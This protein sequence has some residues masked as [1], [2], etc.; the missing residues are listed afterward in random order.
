MYPHRRKVFTM[1]DFNSDK[2]YNSVNGTAPD[3]Y[4]W[5]SAPDKREFKVLGTEVT[6]PKN[7]IV[8]NANEV[9]LYAYYVLS[10]SIVSFE[11]TA[12][13]NERIYAISSRGTLVLEE[14]VILQQPVPVSFKASRETRAI[15]ISRESLL[16]AV[17]SDPDI[18]M[19]II[20]S[21][22]AKLL[23]AM[24]VI[25]QS[26]S[27]SAAWKICNLLLIFASQY[28]VPYDNKILIDT[29]LSQQNIANLLGLNRITTLRVMK[30]LKDMG[31][32]EQI[33]GFYCVRSMDSLMRHMEYLENES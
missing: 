30:D 10:G 11:Y 13:G 14:S 28:G 15:K 26:T 22:S 9:P 31:I 8:H 1:I 25:R 12:S 21:T 17:A 18:A 16:Q 20:R 2:A 29:K 5:R 19:E 4:L 32:I 24:E 23:S 27:T 7:T 33:N 3:P 6:I